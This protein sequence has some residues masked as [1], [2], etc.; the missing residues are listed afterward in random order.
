MWRRV[1]QRVV[2][3]DAE[4]AERGVE[5][6][7]AARARRAAHAGVRRAAAAALRQRRV[8]EDAD[9]VIRKAVDHL[10]RGVLHHHVG[11]GAAAVHAG[12]QPQVREPEIVLQPDAAHAAEWCHARIDQ[13]PVDLILAQ[14]RIRDGTLHRL[15]GE[16]LRIV[17]VHAPHLGDAESR[18]SSLRPEFASVHAG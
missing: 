9:D 5:P 14:P 3:V 18:D 6:A 17:P 10:H 13:Q 16:V 12:K 4:D 8:G 11:S 15:C 7:H 2:R 1:G